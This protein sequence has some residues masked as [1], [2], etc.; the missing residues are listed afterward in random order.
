MEVMGEGKRGRGE[1][2]R[3]VEKMYNAVKTIKK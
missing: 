1:V 3:R 2:W